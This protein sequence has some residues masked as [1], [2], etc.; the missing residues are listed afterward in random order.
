MKRIL[1]AL[2]LI[3]AIV[4]TVLWA[5]QWLFLLVVSA[6]AAMCFREF[7]GIAAAHGLRV[8]LPVGLAAGLV[9]LLAPRADTL[10]FALLAMVALALILPRDDLSK[11]L[12]QA[13]VLVLGVVYIFG[14]W[15]AA[16][17]L[18]GIHPYWLL[19]GLSLTWVG[20]IT[21]FYAGRALG[22]HRLASR[23]SPKKSWEGSV[24]SVA[25]SVAFGAVY[26]SRLLPEVPPG[27]GM[28]LAAAANAAGQLGDLSES[29]MKRGAGVKDSG[30]LLPGH[31]GWLDRV[32]STL[33][34][35]PVLYLLLSRPWEG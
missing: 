32:D 1:T 31:G 11:G 12:P 29:A 4:Y 22:R 2:V 20:D 30:S 35:L 27:W 17:G 9:V 10:F 5:P 6:I 14:C 15:R 19:F 21:A 24:A 13:G 3:P 33:F 18:R 16:A 34:A 7:A 28:A 26:F 25:A 23:V 8:P